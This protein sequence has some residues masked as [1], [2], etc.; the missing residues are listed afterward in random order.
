M[1]LAIWLGYRLRGSWGALVSM[2]GIIVPAAFVAVGI[3]SVFASLS[4]FPAT[5][6]VLDGW[7]RRRSGCPCR[8]ASWPGDARRRGA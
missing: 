2:L 8:W 1:N 6:L 7:A 5:H 4:A 3:A